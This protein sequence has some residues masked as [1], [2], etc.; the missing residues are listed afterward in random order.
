MRSCS[1]EYG[2]TAYYRVDA[3]R[4]VVIDM[5][6]IEEKGVF[7]PL[8]QHAGSYKDNLKICIILETSFDWCINGPHHPHHE[9]S[10]CCW[11]SLWLMSGNNTVVNR[12]ERGQMDTFIRNGAKVLQ[13]WE[14]STCE[15][16]HYLVL[17]LVINFVASNAKV[18][19]YEVCCTSTQQILTRLK[20]VFFF[21][22]LFFYTEH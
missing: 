7:L 17:I 15:T 5:F 12:P 2:V 11:S 9:D 10:F 22:N 21:F 18:W 16:P 4:K 8:V 14:S 1:A 19:R 13:S 20:F 3:Y 6:C